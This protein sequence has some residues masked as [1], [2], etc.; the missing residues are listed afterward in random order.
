M[1]SFALFQLLFLLF[2]ADVLHASPTSSPPPTVTLDKGSFEGTTDAVVDKFLGI[3]C[4]KPPIGNLRF[5]LPVPNDPYTGTHS[6]TNFGPACHQLA[7]KS[8][9]PWALLPPETIQY[10]T[11][12]ALGAPNSTSED[13]LSVNVVT[14][15]G[16]KPGANLPVAVWIYGGGFETGASS[17]Y[18]GGVIVSRS[19]AL[20][21]PIIYVSLNYRLSA[22]GFLASQE[23]KDAGLGNAGLYDQRQALRWV[24]KYIS[25]FGGDPKKVTIWGESAGA[26]SVSL[27]ML[28]NGGNNEGLFRAAF[29]ESGFP[30]PQGD[31]TNGQPYY[32]ALVAETACSNASDTLE[33]LRGA[34]YDTFAAAVDKSPDIFAYQSIDEAWVPRVD[35]KFLTDN[36]QKLVLKGS[37]ARVPFVAGDCDDE[38]TLF[39]LSSTNVTTES[40]VRDYITT[41]FVRGAASSD[42]DALLS[43]YPA[44]VTQGSPFDTGNANAISPQF[45]RISA[46]LG[47]LTFQAPRRLFLQYT[48]SKQNSWVFLSKRLKTLPVL[49]STHASDIQNIFGGGDLTDFLVNFVNHLDPNGNGATKYL[50]W[51]KFDT[52]SLN[53]M[54]LLDGS[55]PQKITKDTYRKDGMDLL[56][57]VTL[58]HPL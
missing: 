30:I 11:Q 19:I 45:K 42:V 28:T 37:V 12:P 2:A 33:C 47:D 35:G 32:D 38:G 18:D 17:L 54:T 40:Q 14:P 51:P 8:Q 15:A 9:L 41:Y 6:A 57:K 50:S 31:I 16:T 46:F 21:E 55:V 22:F 58:E 56:M 29:M 1:V 27:Q 26:I 10:L 53:L 3:P 34:P 49:G 4:A 20:R 36:P 13:C 52:N 7:L 43:L 23:V 24:Q 44:D 39:A 48:A 25:A 5:R